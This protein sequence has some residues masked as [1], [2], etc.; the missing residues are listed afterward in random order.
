M[1]LLIELCVAQTRQKYTSDPLYY[2]IFKINGK[3]RVL[4][5]VQ[6]YTCDPICVILKMSEQ[7]VVVLSIRCFVV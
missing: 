4:L 7:Y 1:L 2:V 3:N 6:K 5:V